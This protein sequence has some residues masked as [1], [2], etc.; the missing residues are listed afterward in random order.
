MKTTLKTLIKKLLIPSAIIAALT[1]RGTAQTF[2]DLYNLIRLLWSWY[3]C[4]NDLI[5]HHL[6]WD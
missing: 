3:I 5:G 2:T 4:R 6:V 1:D